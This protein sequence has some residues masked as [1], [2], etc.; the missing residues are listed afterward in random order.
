VNIPE[1][2]KKLIALGVDKSANLQDLNDMTDRGKYTMNPWTA[3]K[4]FGT[5][6]LIKQ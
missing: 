2:Y 5:I 1:E 6:A 3:S 4:T